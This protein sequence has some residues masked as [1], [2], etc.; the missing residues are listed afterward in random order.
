MPPPGRISATPPNPDIAKSLEFYDRIATAQRTGK[1]VAIPSTERPSGPFAR[2]KSIRSENISTDSAFMLAQE[3]LKSNVVS[4]HGQWGWKQLVSRVPELRSLPELHRDALHAGTRPLS[5]L[6]D[7]DALKTKIS[8][9]YR[10]V[11][12]LAQQ[13]K[14]LIGARNPEVDQG[15]IA[16]KH[17]AGAAASAKETR[18]VA[19]QWAIS[20]AAANSPINRAL[21]KSILRNTPEDRLKVIKAFDDRM[22]NTLPSGNDQRTVL[23][24]T[25]TEVDAIARATIAKFLLGD[26]THG[27]FDNYESGLEILAE[28]LTSDFAPPSAGWGLASR[29]A[30]DEQ[31]MS[32][33]DY[34]AIPLMLRALVRE[35]VRTQ[36]KMPTREAVFNMAVKLASE[37]A[38]KPAQV[39]FGLHPNAI[40]LGM[41][42]EGLGRSDF[43]TVELQKQ[44]EALAGKMGAEADSVDLSTVLPQAMMKVWTQPQIMLDG[45][46]QR[47]SADFAALDQKTAAAIAAA[48]PGGA[49]QFDLQQALPANKL[50]MLTPGSKLFE[51]LR[52]TY[53]DPALGPEAQE[54]YRMMMLDH[55]E[56]GQTDGLGFRAQAAYIEAQSQETAKAGRRDPATLAAICS[57]LQPKLAKAM[58]DHGRIDSM[59]EAPPALQKVFLSRLSAGRDTAAEDGYSSTFIQDLPRTEWVF[60]KDGVAVTEHPG[61]GG[62]AK[63]AKY[64]GLFDGNL[65]AA[66]TLTHAIHQNNIGLLM[67][68]WEA[69][70]YSIGDPTKGDDNFALLHDRGVFPLREPIHYAYTLRRVAPNSVEV[71]YNTMRVSNLLDLKGSCVIPINRAADLQGPPSSANAALLQKIR[72]AFDLD[73]LSEGVLNPRLVQAPQAELHIAPDWGQ[74]ASMRRDGTLNLPR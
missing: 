56:R 28:S 19:D 38:Q 62:P 2:F 17:R 26:G 51:Y 13:I 34:E 23:G 66:K 61:P 70:A 35:S 54:A 41:F 65:V 74:I 8:E 60:E 31:P 22:M 40:D 67:R 10:D 39:Y 32:A 53:P 6:A 52:A 46:G 64:E 5:D 25:E 12:Q 49:V 45:Y 3:Q 57:V 44:V 43:P 72:V 20:S 24:Y 73:D 1:P 42:G 30:G 4:K 16:A 37:H 15:L 55:I 59:V 29:V 50:E 69:T 27:R 18:Q 14:R 63:L 9:A 33:K 36:G 71:E 48:P 11:D 68:D 58:A 47:L 7:A 21:D